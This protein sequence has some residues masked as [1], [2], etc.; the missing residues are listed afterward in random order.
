M[1]GVST[2]KHTIAILFGYGPEVRAFLYSGLIDK[3]L[4]HWNVLVVA[5]QPGSQAFTNLE[6]ISV[7]PMPLT[8]E[9]IVL[10]YLRVSSRRAHAVWLSLQGKRQWRHYLSSS[11][12]RSGLEGAIA[13]RVFKSKRSFEL[14][15]SIERAVGRIYGTNRAWQ[16]LFKDNDV[17]CLLAA[18][19][20]SPRTLP[21][22]QTAANLG[23]KSIVVLNSWKDVYTEPLVHVFPTRIVVWNQHAKNDLS[24]SN[25]RLPVETIKVADSLHLQRFLNSESP[26]NWD[27][28]CCVAGLDHR[29]SFICYTAAAPS[30][31]RNE[32]LIVE[33]LLKAIADGKLPRAPQLLLRLN[34]MEDGTRF[35]RLTR[36]NPNLVVQ[37]PDWEWLPDE[38]W[39]C[40]LL[41]DTKLWLSTVYH[42]ALNV[43]VAS[44][45]TLEFAAFNRPVV[46]IC[47][48]LP[49]AQPYEESNRRFWE[50]DFYRNIRESGYAIPAYSPEQLIDIL[51]HLLLG[52]PVSYGAPSLFLP[53]RNSVQIVYSAV[54]EVLS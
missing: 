49:G 40:P 1:T 27:D 15:L 44:T 53:S 47:F 50:A 36:Y 43:S 42:S 46:N 17:V 48:D 28:F 16:K 33:L 22:L 18:S 26:M 13:K 29:R 54:E 10:R 38:D 8:R 21:A 32:D 51:S 7:V 45:V 2:K 20:A 30:A 31:V 34:P 9:P 19:H 39:C 5:S 37:K 24:A 23:I 3:L 52:N 14:F 4:E 12:K 6:D 35:K 11:R 25:P 41:S